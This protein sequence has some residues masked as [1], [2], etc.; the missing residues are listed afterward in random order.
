MRLADQIADSRLPF[1]VKSSHSHDVVRLH[2]VADYADQV[3]RCPVRYV[4]SDDLTRLCTALAFSKGA[5]SLACA[6]LLH[7]P[8][9]QLW[10]EWCETPW[11]EE[12]ARY[13]FPADA[14]ASP[15]SGRRGALIRSSPEGRRGCV[16]TFWSIGT[17]R[18]DVLASS[19]E[20]YFDFDTPD[21]EEPEPLDDTAV[22]AFAV[23]DRTIRGV[24]ILRRC[25]RFRFERSWAAYYA[26]AALPPAHMNAVVH[27][28]LGTI[29]IDVPILLTFMMLLM[30]RPGIPRR[31]LMLERI[32]R[33]RLKAGK[34][35]LL[36]HIEVFSPLSADYLPG[37][38]SAS[39]DGTRRSPRLHHVRGHLVR[40]GSQISWRV[41]HLRGDA[42]AG[43]VNSRTVTWMI[44]SPSGIA[45]A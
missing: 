5:R 23:A 34:A 24:D 21:G 27:H 15:T 17:G 31:P 7:V 19:M 2:G 25:F 45:P 11:R 44:D 9:A 28:S 18:R 43:L 3:L 13:G 1:Y 29:A 40:R 4:L 39:A 14:R 42:R 41:P 37:A 6:D 35:A 22:A 10:I 30:S 32:N 20:A 33:A 16:K 36:P 26:R 38:G 8:A 12:L